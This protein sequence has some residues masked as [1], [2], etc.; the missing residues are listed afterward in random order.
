MHYVLNLL[1]AHRSPLLPRRRELFLPH[2]SLR[3]I[4]M[5]FVVR[6]FDGREGDFHLLTQAMRR[7]EET[8]GAVGLGVE[9]VQFGKPLYGVGKKR[10]GLG[11]VEGLEIKAAG[12]V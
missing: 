1:H 4:D 2:L 6:A 9:N 8:R 12:G 7:A 11:Q 10:T 3:H 5:L